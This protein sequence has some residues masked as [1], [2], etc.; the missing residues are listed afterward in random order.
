MKISGLSRTHPWASSASLNAA[1]ERKR[2]QPARMRR[3]R[4]P[5]AADAKRKVALNLDV[6]SY[7]STWR[8]KIASRWTLHLPNFETADSRRSRSRHV[9]HTHIDTHTHTHRVVPSEFSIRPPRTVENLERI[10]I[11]CNRSRRAKIDL[12]ALARELIHLHLFHRHVSRVK[13]RRVET[14][15]PRRHVQRGGKEGEE[16]KWKEFHRELQLVSPL[17]SARSGLQKCARVGIREIIK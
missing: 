4:F 3:S 2:N 16:K 12:R 14:I 9:I 13:S 1:R 7:S 6:E 5:N 8:G 15:N 11:T 10:A 17:R